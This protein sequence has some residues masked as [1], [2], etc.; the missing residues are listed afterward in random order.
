MPTSKEI[1][2][3][4]FALEKLERAKRLRAELAAL[5]TEL[6][7]YGLTLPEEGSTKP[8]K[9]S[10]APRKSYPEIN[11]EAVKEF[12]KGKDGNAYASDLQAHFGVKFQTWRKTNE[13]SFTVKKDGTS[14]IWQNK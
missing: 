9:K 6:A 5:E 3:V 8:A 7:E 11:V 14:K 4:K 1:K 2:T 13:K 12:I 10:R